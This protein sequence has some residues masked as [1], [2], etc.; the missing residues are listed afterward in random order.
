MRFADVPAG[1]P[2]EAEAAFWPGCMPTAAAAADRA[3]ARSSMLRSSA[4]IKPC[5]SLRFC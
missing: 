2:E 5:S 3:E 4:A 1:I